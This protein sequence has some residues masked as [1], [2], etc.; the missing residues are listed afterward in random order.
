VFVLTRL[1]RFYRRCGMTRRRAF[2]RALDITL[3]DISITKFQP[4]R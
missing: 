4:R 2:A 3:R 1:F